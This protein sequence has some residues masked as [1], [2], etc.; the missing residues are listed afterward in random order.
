[1]QNLITYTHVLFCFYF[2]MD[3]HCLKLLNGEEGKCDGGGGN[4][5]GKGRVGTAVLRVLFLVKFWR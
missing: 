5:T 3:F 2:H 1:M 4:S